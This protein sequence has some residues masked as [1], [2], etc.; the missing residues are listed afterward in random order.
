MEQASGDG[1][2]WV[3][4]AAVASVAL[5]AGLVLLRTRTKAEVKLT[6]AAI[7]LIP[8]I[9]VLL[10]TG[11]I[12]KLVVGP[13][14]VT[15][16]TAREAILDAAGQSVDA[17]IERIEPEPVE[18]ASK[19]GVDK[20]PEYLARGIQALT[21]QISARYVP[22]I[23]AAY[24]RELSTSPSF[25]YMVL[26]EPDG[27]FYGIMDARKLRSLV[28]PSDGGFGGRDLN[29]D[30]IRNWIADDPT[31]F[32]ELPSFVPAGAALPADA[33]KRAALTRLQEED[34]D[35]LPAVDEEG[36]FTGVVDHARLTAGLILDV[37]DRLEAAPAEE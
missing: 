8:L 31:A 15:V 32:A 23:M 34:R 20:I 24:F 3:L 9:A 21:F 13:E 26:V 1:T 30:M 37:A 18:A 5:L 6:D 22:D 33:S 17:Q 25:R 11:K 4:V 27:R 28:E 10:A 29:W 2:I 7:A 36:R 35:W 19:R 14:G 12:N 16:E